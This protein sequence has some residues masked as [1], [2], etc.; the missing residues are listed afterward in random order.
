MT[1]QAIEAVVKSV[2]NAYPGLR[3]SNRSEW[4]NKIAYICYLKDKTV[5]R[6]STIGGPIS[7]DTIGISVN[8][9][10][11]TFGQHFN[12]IP[13]EGVDLVN[14][15]SGDIQW[16][17]YGMI[18]NQT[19][20]IPFV[21]DVSAVGSQPPPAVGVIDKATA[22]ARLL[23]I[24]A[25][26]ESQLGLKRPG[27]MVIDSANPVRADIEA[28]GQWQY[29]IVLGTEVESIKSQIRHS[30]EWQSKHPGEMPF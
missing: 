25:F 13:F 8:P 7:D 20:I 19:F 28:L 6:K 17:S 22:Y 26:Y 24:N 5:G 21:S 16:L 9:I 23:E 10:T 2:E 15:N 18:N 11:G 30:G 4:T 3:F 29:Q 12:N 1:K 14:G 27:G